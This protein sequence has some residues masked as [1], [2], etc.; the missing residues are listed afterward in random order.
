[1]PTVTDPEKVTLFHHFQPS[2]FQYN[3]QCCPKNLGL[4]ALNRS[5]SVYSEQKNRFMEFLK[6][7]LEL[8]LEVVYSLFLALK[9]QFSSVILGPKGDI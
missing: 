7:G 6:A 4:G 1:M 8:C 2:Y 9:D 5:P 3:R